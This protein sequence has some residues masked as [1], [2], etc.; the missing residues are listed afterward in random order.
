[1][2]DPDLQRNT[3]NDLFLKDPEEI[4]DEEVRLITAHMRERRAVWER[5]E[6]AK[7]RGGKKVGR[8]SESASQKVIGDK[9]LA[10]IDIDLDDVDLT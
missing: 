7:V 5:E 3:I 10:D 4:T 6:L 8:K 2:E 9:E 1:L